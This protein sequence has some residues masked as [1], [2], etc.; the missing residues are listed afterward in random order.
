MTIV[1][2]RLYRIGQVAEEA[3]VTPRTIRYYEEVGLLRSTTSRAKGTHRLYTGEDVARLRELIRF[4]N[5]LGLSL[6]ELV[7]LA[8]TEEMREALRGQWLED[9]TDANRARI[10]R[11]SIPLVERQLELVR[12]RQQTLAEFGAELDEKLTSLRLRLEELEG[13]PRRRSR[14]RRAAQPVQPGRPSS[15]G[16]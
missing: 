7:V 9:P 15:T 10:V 3:G 5:L 2:D 1:S 8:E 16:T 6:E 12:Q 14:S 13:G 4:R 11:A